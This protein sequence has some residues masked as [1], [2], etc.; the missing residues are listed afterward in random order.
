MK[1]S[2]G[3]LF[4]GKCVNAKRMIARLALTSYD[5]CTFYFSFF[6]PSFLFSYSQYYLQLDYFEGRHVVVIVGIAIFSVLR[7][8]MSNASVTI[9]NAKLMLCI[10][11][12]EINTL[13]SYQF[14]YF[15]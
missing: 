13:Y 8:H 7:K 10:S 3:F 5:A 6:F 12:R 15:V 9:T 1:T 4:T 2:V 14:A 11:N